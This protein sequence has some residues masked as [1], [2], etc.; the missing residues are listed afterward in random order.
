LTVKLIT[1]K[2]IRYNNK[3]FG[4]LSKVLDLLLWH[5][6][7]VLELD[8]LDFVGKGGALLLDNLQ[9]RQLEGLFFPLS[10]DYWAVHY[11]WGL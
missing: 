2:K 3:K 7:L 4:L 8:N 6:I 9:G 1:Q 5:P 10:L 11:K